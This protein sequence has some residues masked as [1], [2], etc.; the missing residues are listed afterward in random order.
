MPRG[1][2]KRSFIPVADRLW[3]MVDKTPGGCWNFTGCK[4][5]GY[6]QIRDGS[7]AALAHRVSYEIARGPVPD[8]LEL[9]HLCRNRSCVRPDH[10][11]AVDT[12]TNVLRG[13]GPT[14]INARKT[15]CSK[16]HEFSKENT[17]RHCD[18]GRVCIQCTRIFDR[19]FYRKNVLKRREASR[20][21]RI[22][23]NPDIKLRA[24]RGDCASRLD[25]Q[26]GRGTAQNKG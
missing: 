5:K 20:A 9:D 24:D 21:Y 22:K 12:K 17:R 1:I 15:H 6:G 13:N 19:A 7:K 18:G 14:A 4:M 8:G 26:T 2:Y 3:A 16:G 11:E 25:A 23:K 10:L